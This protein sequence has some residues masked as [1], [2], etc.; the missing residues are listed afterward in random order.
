MRASGPSVFGAHKLSAVPLVETTEANAAPQAPERFDPRTMR[1]WLIEAE[2]LARYRWV[3]PLVRDKRVLDAG[4]GTAYGSA[5]LAGANATEVVGVDHDA[6]VLES[7]RP[8]MPGNVSLEAADVRNLPHADGSFDVA[9]CFEVIE[10][11]DDPEDVVAELR[12]VL[13]NDGLLVVSSPNRGVYPS[14]NPHHKREFLPDEL[15]KMLASRFDGV[16]LL[17]QHDWL[18][19]AVL[20]DETFGFDDATAFEA[21]VRKTVAASPGSELYT[22]AL[23]SSAVLPAVAPEV[24]LTQTADAKWWQ[25]K[26]TELEGDR[27]A[28]RSDAR[29]LQQTVRDLEA[30]IAA[31]ESTLNDARSEIDELNGSLRAMQE[32]RVWRTASSYWRLRDRLLRHARGS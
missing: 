8:S 25:E 13:R 24:V 7:V 31:C 22:V 9:V 32:T 19:S 23:A 20:E 30:K 5:I 10:H 11:V 14:G 3:A 15:A 18:A 29:A 28:A 6:A 2:H 12:R 21:T 17:R 26:L 16:R 4:C 27:D 1:G